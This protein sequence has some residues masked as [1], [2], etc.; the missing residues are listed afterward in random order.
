MA[1][2][3]NTLTI[4]FFTLLFY[5]G[6]FLLVKFGK[7]KKINQRRFWNVVLLFTFLAS[8]FLGIV[9]AVIIDYGLIVMSY[10]QL[11]TLH[12]RIG[13]VMA[14]IAFIHTLSHWRYYWVIIKRKQN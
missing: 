13:M 4:I 6:S 2:A 7:V 12:V 1:E 3:Y 11:L 9:M 14:V 10:P 8:A 5:F